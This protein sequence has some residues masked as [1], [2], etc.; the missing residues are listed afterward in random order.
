[1]TLFSRSAWRA[2]LRQW[3]DEF[4]CHVDPLL[5]VEM[6]RRLDDFKQHCRYTRLRH[7]VDVAYLSFL[8]AKLL[9]W[10]SR[11][12]ARAGLLHDLFFHSEGQNSASLIR[13]HPEIALANARAICRIN[14]LEEDIIL[15]HMFMLTFA[16]PSYKESYLVTLVD[17]YCAGREFILSL[18]LPARM[19]TAFVRQPA[20]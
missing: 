16:L 5:Q 17:K 13:S 6:V 15:K 10:D 2:L 7:S 11:S 1:M 4:S 20:A 19:R 9:G 3:R 8:I 12:V 18:L 14:P